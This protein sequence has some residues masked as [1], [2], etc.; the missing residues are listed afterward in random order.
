MNKLFSVVIATIMMLS[1]S[2][3]AEMGKDQFTQ[4][5]VGLGQSYEKALQICRDQEYSHFLFQ[6]IS[7]SDDQGQTM[8]FKN[9]R[10]SELGTVIKE[11]MNVDLTPA[12]GSAFGKQKVEFEIL[13][14]K[15]APKD[16]MAID[17]EAVYDLMQQF[18]APLQAVEGSLVKEVDSLEALDA[19]LADAEGLVF[20]D[21][22]S[23]CCPPC[24]MLS[25]K[26]DQFSMDL[27]GKGLLLKMNTDVVEDVLYRYHIQS[28][29][30]LIIFERG[31][32]V[33]Q[34]RGLPEIVKY[35][36]QLAEIQ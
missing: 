25:P 6:R 32:V 4:L 5:M 10:S 29:P 23:T 1:S 20:L 8:E 2:L 24:R 7:C 30:T 3:Q 14:F 18:S 9:N 31:E 35:F 26:Y 15:S 17:V 19:A 11:T 13:C 33:A 27:E 16:P 21:C 36:E 34:K 12:M 22:Y 28:V